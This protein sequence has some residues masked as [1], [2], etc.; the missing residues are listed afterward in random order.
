MCIVF[1]DNVAEW[2]EIAIKQGATKKSD[3][4]GHVGRVGCPID[5]HAARTANV[6]RYGS[7]AGYE[8]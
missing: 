3:D 8:T 4:R 6:S 5:Y 2:R 1:A 7:W